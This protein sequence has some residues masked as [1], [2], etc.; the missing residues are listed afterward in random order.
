M[1]FCIVAAPI[2]I[3][4]NGVG[5]FPF[6]HAFSKHLVFKGFSILTSRGASL[7]T[8]QVKNLPAMQ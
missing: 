8:Q 3:P 1:L 2:Y 6:L 7:M 4:T 5:G